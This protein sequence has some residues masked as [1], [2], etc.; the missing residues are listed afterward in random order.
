MQIAYLFDP[1]CGWCYGAGPALEQLSR[2]SGIVLKLSPT[3]LFAGENA[4]M[5]NSSFAAYAWQNDQ[6]IARLTG[7]EFSQS[8]RDNILGADGA[9]FDSAPATLGLVAVGLTAPEREIEALKLLQNAR[10]VDGRNNS[11]L[12]VVADVL[13]AAGLDDAAV[14]IT[15]P[16]PDLPEV[17]RH[18]IDAARRDMTHSGAQGVPSLIVEGEGGRQMLPGNMLFGDI[19]ALASRLKAA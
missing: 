2:L 15:S 12:S 8:Y 3:G 14:R 11:D 6:R 1:L 17:Y 19:T 7:Q 16:D 9:M 10:Y 13:A 4:R 5:M 18:R